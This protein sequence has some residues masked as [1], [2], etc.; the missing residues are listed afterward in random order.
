MLSMHATLQQKRG[1]EYHNYWVISLK[2]SVVNKKFVTDVEADNTT[3][4]PSKIDQ[5]CGGKDD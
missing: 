5:C 4:K 2:T 3:Y 1:T